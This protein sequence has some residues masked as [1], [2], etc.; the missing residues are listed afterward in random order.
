M[1]KL[2]FVQGFKK[3]S[4][5]RYI[6]IVV[7]WARRKI[8]SGQ[9]H[10]YWKNACTYA[11]RGLLHSVGIGVQF[12]LFI[13]NGRETDCSLHKVL[14]SGRESIDHTETISRSACKCGEGE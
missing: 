3:N 14:T 13:F 1:Q 5:L 10:Q 4:F 6:K 2:L 9:E 12:Y 8:R 7:I 11:K